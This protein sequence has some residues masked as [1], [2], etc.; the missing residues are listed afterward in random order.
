M[1][2]FK[3]GLKFDMDGLKADME[4]LKEGLTKFFQEKFPSGDK[5]IH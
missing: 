1:E 4:D 3:D 2:D 5:A